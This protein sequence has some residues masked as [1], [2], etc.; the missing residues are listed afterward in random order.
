M[1][2]PIGV[3]G[4]VWGGM[5]AGGAAAPGQPATH[6]PH[7]FFVRHHGTVFF[8]VVQAEYVLPSKVNG[9]VQGSPFTA[10]QAPCPAAI[11]ATEKKL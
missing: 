2:L 8:T 1:E 11:G 4:A 3:G 9:N 10:V 7:P 6:S 5:L